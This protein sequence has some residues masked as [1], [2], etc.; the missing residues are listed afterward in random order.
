MANESYT[1]EEIKKKFT[2]L[3]QDIKA[4]V[5][6]VDMLNVI[7]KLGEKYQLHV[8][9]LEILE[10]EAADIMT[11]LSDPKTFVSNIKESLEI[12]ETKAN[13]LAKD[14]NEQLFDKIRES[15]KKVYEQNTTPAAEAPK[16]P[17][18]MSVEKS[19]VMP[20]AAKTPADVPA[21]TA[22]TP[23]PAAPAPA[24]AQPK[25]IVPPAPALTPTPVAAPA[26]PKADVMLSQP[27]VSLPAGQSPLGG[28][29][30]KVP[31][32]PAQPAQ[33]AIK[34]AEP[35]KADAPKPAPIYKADPYREPPE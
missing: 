27:T 35:P 32:Q 26:I 5:Y 21:V 13:A 34:N 12:D 1:A 30:S 4:L 8:D 18:A 33:S 17:P 11:G 7:Q 9:K 2:S 10:G 31:A 22:P 16:N 28:A 25:P 15:M 19:V 6:S 29:Q 23:A 3:P 14:V 24:S 20:S